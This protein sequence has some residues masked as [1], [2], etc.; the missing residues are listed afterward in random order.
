MGVRLE[1]ERFTE[2]DSPE[3]LYNKMAAQM[4]T[5]CESGI[6]GLMVTIPESQN[7]KGSIKLC[8]LLNI[9]VI[10]VNSNPQVSEEVGVVQHI[11]QDE[12]QAGY[13]AGLEMLQAGM[14]EGYCL[15]Q[16]GNSG[17]TAR[18]NGFVAAIEEKGDGFR[19]TII[20][21]PLDL[22]SRFTFVFEEAVAR[23]DDWSGV[24]WLVGARHL[25]PT[26]R[27]QDNHQSLLIG[28]FDVG[29]YGD[30]IFAALDEGRLLFT[31]DQ[32]PYL[33]GNLPVYLLSYMIYTQQR[34]LDQ[35]ILTG[36]SLIKSRPTP[37]QQ[38]CEANLYEVCS[39]IPKE[40]LNYI[41]P[42]WLYVGYFFV[43]LT[44]L[45]GLICL[46][47]L[48]YFREKSIVRAR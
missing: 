21:A 9:P 2:T 43:G 16:E 23:D 27:V 41:N 17:V 25:E 20:N 34:L 5:L 36:P 39:L 7:I 26:L 38:T 42:G 22:D 30:I 44:V 45:A 3:I 18:C 47:W 28:M 10:A 1:L 48:Y 33:Q 19:G 37:E 40:D 6:D 8:Q 4:R 24:G 32:Q 11:G 12:L 46:V 29:S 31:S 15:G 14:K 13:L 35:I